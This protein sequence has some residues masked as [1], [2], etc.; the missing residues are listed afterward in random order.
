LAP[1]GFILLGPAG[2]QVGPAEKQSGGQEGKTM[3][4]DGGC[5]CGRIAYRA[6]IDPQLVEL[7]HCTDCQVMSGSAFRIVVPTAESNFE[8]LS[9][10]LKT[11]VKTGESGNK[12]I[13]AFCPE[14]GT[15]IYSTSVGEGSRT[16]GLRVGAIKQRHKLPPTKQYW[17]RSAHAWVMDLDDIEKVLTQ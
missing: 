9:G 5:H 17:V 12:R 13:Q 4:V 7:C 14:C 16:F 1:H 10:M 15:H 3:Q 6:E 11:Y 8:L 2:G